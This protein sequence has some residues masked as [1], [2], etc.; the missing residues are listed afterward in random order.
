MPLLPTIILAIVMQLPQHIHAS[1]SHGHNPF[2]VLDQGAPV[3][4]AGLG[5]MIMMGAQAFKLALQQCGGEAATTIFLDDSTRNVATAT[6]MGMFTVQVRS[7]CCLC[8]CLLR[9]HSCS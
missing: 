9:L 3:A 8:M 2:L 6:R 4:D 5:D 1:T 7:P